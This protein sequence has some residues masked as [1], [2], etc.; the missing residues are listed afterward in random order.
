MSLYHCSEVMPRVAY[1]YLVLLLLGSKT[2]PLAEK[3]SIFSVFTVAVV[4][5]LLPL[6]IVMK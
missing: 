1:L 2:Q 6:A 4:V 5:F 3:D